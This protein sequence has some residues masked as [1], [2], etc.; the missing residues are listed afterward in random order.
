MSPRPLLCRA[1]VLSD[2]GT[3]V[4]TEAPGQVTHTPRAEAGLSADR[5]GDF[6]ILCSH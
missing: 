6:E 3:P 2:M 4:Q 1:R 5:E